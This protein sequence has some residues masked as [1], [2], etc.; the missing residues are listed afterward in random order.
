MLDECATDANSQF[1][2]QGKMLRIFGSL[3]YK[4]N[5]SFVTISLLSP[6]RRN[7]PISSKIGEIICPYP[8]ELS[9]SSKARINK[10]ILFDSGT[11]ISQVPF[12]D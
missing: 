1:W 5:I 3:S 8:P 11:S 9:M 12:G 2:P 7:T 6:M 4:S 10:L